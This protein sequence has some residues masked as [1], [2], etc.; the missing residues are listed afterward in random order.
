LLAK[1]RERD[2]SE[3]PGVLAIERQYLLDERE[4]QVHAQE[5]DR[6]YEA[7]MQLEYEGVQLRGV[8]RLYRRVVVVEPTTACAANCRWCLR[9]QY[10]LLNL[11]EEDLE[12]IA[13]YIGDERTCGG[14]REVLVTGGDPLMVPGRIGF[15]LDTLGRVAPNVQVVRIGSRLPVQEPSRIDLDVLRMLSSKRSFRLE[16][17]THVNHP[18]ELCLESREALKKISDTGVRIYDQTV[19]LKGVNDDL[20]ILVELYDSLRELGVEAHYLFHCVPLH[21]AQ[22]HRTSVDRGL[23]LARVLSSCGRI[24]GRSKPIFA[25][26]TAIGKVVLYDGAVADRRENKLLL[27]SGYSLKERMTW[28]PSWKLPENAVVDDQ[29]MLLVWYLDGQD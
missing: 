5:R 10:D 7:D 24:S 25:A 22:H 1:L 28:N 26:M 13:R 18:V 15:F 6:H 14:V 2:G 20:D 19:L 29:G 11:K 12:R 4:S 9:S 17:A 16:V 3:S 21:G 27:R 23:Q 8:E